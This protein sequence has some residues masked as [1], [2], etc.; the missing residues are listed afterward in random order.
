MPV[1][2][3]AFWPELMAVPPPALVGTT[4]VTPS[5]HLQTS[6]GTSITLSDNPAQQV[7]LKTA[8]GALLTIGTA[9]IT[10]TNGQGA[11]IA[12]VGASVII[13]NGALTVT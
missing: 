13:N 9:G 4:P 8:T 11:S 1:W 2:T 5:I 3:G 7:M 6:L 12:M 10:I